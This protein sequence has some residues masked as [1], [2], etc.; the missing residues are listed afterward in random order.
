MK[1]YVTVDEFQ[2]VS[3]LVHRLHPALSRFIAY[4]RRTADPNRPDNNRDRTDKRPN[5]RTDAR[6]SGRTD[7]DQNRTD[8]NRDRTDKRQNDRT[9]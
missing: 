4:L 7:K 2:R 1:E 3:D 9:D 6:Q 8:N 5:D